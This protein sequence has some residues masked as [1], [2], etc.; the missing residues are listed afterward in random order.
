VR[1]CVKKE[2]SP[3]AW[4]LTKTTFS[5][6]VFKFMMVSVHESNIDND[7]SG[8]EAKLIIHVKGTPDW[9]ITLYSNHDQAGLAG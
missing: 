1:D 4:W 5:L 3:V 8:V 6:S 2:Y 9:M 7:G